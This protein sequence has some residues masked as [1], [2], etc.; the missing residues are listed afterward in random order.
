MYSMVLM[1]AVTTGGDAASFGHKGGC[2]GNSCSGGGFI[3][4]K[5]NGC[6]GGDRLALSE[7]NSPTAG[8]LPLRTATRTR[9]SLVSS[10]PSILYT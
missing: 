7:T 1:V 5:S 9:S 6:S 3:G 4:H 10:A 2:T 8:A